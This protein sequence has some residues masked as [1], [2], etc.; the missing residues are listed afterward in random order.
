MAHSLRKYIS[1]RGSALFMVISTMTALMIACMA[2]YFSVVSSRSTQ[3]AVFNQ[4]QS[5]QSAVSIND[6]ILAGLMDG[7]LTS[8]DKDLLTAITDLKPGETLTTGLDGFGTNDPLQMGMSVVDIKRLEDEVIDG[9]TN[10]TLD[11]ATTTTVNGVSDTVHMYIHIDM[12]KAAGSPGGDAKIFAATGYVPNDAYLD[13]GKFFTDVFFDTEY[14]FINM[15]G[16]TAN[17]LSG[18]IYTGGSLWLKSYLL[19]VKPG[20]PSDVDASSL[21]KPT[22]WGVRGD[23]ISDCN[24]PIQLYAGSKVF[25]GG[26]LS[27]NNGGGFD[28]IGSGRIDVYVNGDLYIPGSVGF[29]NVNLHVN[30]DIHFGGWSSWGD[31]GTAARTKIYMNGKAV[32]IGSGD[33]KDLDY[34]NIKKWDNSATDSLSVSEFLQE[35]DTATNTKTYYKWVINGSDKTKKDYIPELDPKNPPYDA[36]SHKSTGDK[37]TAFK[38]KLNDGQGTPDGVPKFTSVFTIAYPGSKSEE[39]AKKNGV[40]CKAG[41]IEGFEGKVGDNIIPT[42]IV[43]DTGDDESNTIVLRVTAYLDKDND[44]KSETFAWTNN[45]GLSSGS[46]TVLVKGRGSVIIDVPEGVTYQDMNMQQFMHYSWFKLLGGE[47]SDRTEY[48]NEKYYEDELQWDGVVRPVEKWHTVEYNF[49]TYSSQKIQAQ[50][51]QAAVKSVQFL[52]SECKTGDKC[53]YTIVDYKEDGTTMK[54]EICSTTKK[55]VMCDKHNKVQTFCPNCETDTAT[56]AEEIKK[57]FDDGTAGVEGLCVNHVGRAEIDAYLADKAALKKE[58]SDSKGLIY[59]TT[60]IFLVN[61]TESAEMRFSTDLSGTSI[62]QN[63]FY[64]YIYAPYMT[65]KAKGNSGTAI[66][67][68]F[69]GLTVSDYV[70]SDTYAFTGCYPEKMPNELMGESSASSLNGLST[71]SWK[72]SLGSY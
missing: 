35:L 9:K 21:I 32:K 4:Q 10:M 68:F 36:A 59:P 12:T 24:N 31:E 25:V 29:K 72:I 60:N 1:N 40:I 34:L 44:G 14:T 39:D 47:E 45:T 52:H 7:T 65:F 61:S 30:G 69:G 51:T 53:K 23:M 70:I 71:K 56:K 48:Q 6:M 22:V 55:A 5:Y 19:P 28:V 64:G 38:I 3:Y 15:Y 26:D 41:V 63:S 20:D 37:Y 13:G 43:I 50:G 62:I 17:Y 27:F 8:G 18:S 66:N 16:G 57:A 46:F 67:R 42:A 54:C 2:M 33:P 49:H 11:I 58:M